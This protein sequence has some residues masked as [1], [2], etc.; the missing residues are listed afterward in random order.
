M[1]SLAFFGFLFACA[2]VA[3]PIEP[4]L[5]TLD[6]YA[7]ATAAELRAR[8]WRTDF[9]RLEVPIE[10][11]HSGQLRRDAFQV[12]RELP[13]AP[14]SAIELDPAE[15][16]LV[17]RGK[18]D[19]V[20]AWPLVHL[21]RR[22]LAYDEVDGVAL[23]VTYCSLCDLARVFE[24]K[25]NGHALGLAVSGLLIDGNAVLFDKETDSLWRQRDGACFAGEHSGERLDVLP[26]FMASFGALRSAHPEARV[27]L[28][29]DDGAPNPPLVLMSADHVSSGDPPSW[30]HAQCEAPLERVV[31]L[32]TNEV[33]TIGTRLVEHVQGVVILRDPSTA[34]VH[35]AQAGELGPAIGSAAAF[36]AQLDGRPVHFS[37][38]ARGVFDQGTGSRWN[39]LGEAVDGVLMGRKL[40][41]APHATSFRFAVELER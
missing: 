29:A 21:L 39:T 3:A 34:S 11:V 27:R 18:D 6:G 33:H 23:A 8:G 13:R 14:A 28:A 25:L 19:V 9:T 5:V 15:P 36:L 41:P 37:T 1:R 17:L 40:V 31:L 32:G 2:P 4:S 35:R 20:H 12:I 24:R 7:P 30:L 10:H 26:T 16:V 38:D 22:E